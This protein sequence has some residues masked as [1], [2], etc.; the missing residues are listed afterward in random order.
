MRSLAKCKLCDPHSLQVG[1][2]TSEP[3]SASAIQ[4]STPIKEPLPWRQVGPN[5]FTMDFQAP[6]SAM[7]AFAVCLSAFDH[8]LACE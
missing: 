6:M 8:K 4:T 2:K 3:F 7:Q 5:M 1:R